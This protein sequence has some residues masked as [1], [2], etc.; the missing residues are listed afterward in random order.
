MTIAKPFLK[1]AGGKRQLVNILD[2]CLPSKIRETKE[3]E[4]YAEPFIGGGA[5]LFHVLSFYKVKKSII[6]DINPDLM[7]TYTVVQKYPEELIE[8]LR[9]IEKQYLKFNEKEKEE[10]YYALRKVFNELR[11]DFNKPVPEVWVE[12]ASL[13]IVLNKLCFNGL[14]RQNSKGEFN[15]PMGKYKNPKILDEGNILNASKL[16]QYT[17]VHCG[18]YL[19]INFAKAEKAFVYLDP[20]YRPLPKTSAFT[21]YSKEDFHDEDQK[22]LSKYFRKMD[23]RGSSLLLSNSDTGDGFFDKM[24]QGYCIEKVRS[25][26]FI[27]SNGYGRGEVSE[28]LIRNYQY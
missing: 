13:L 12:K 3:I 27:N 14:F 28:L 4:L 7:I 8:K 24:Y 6:N 25:K 15:V 16:L 18:S 19:G 21:K 23:K 1:W 11:V 2:K 22:E 20:P 17:E 10:Y 5:F 9:V 26:R